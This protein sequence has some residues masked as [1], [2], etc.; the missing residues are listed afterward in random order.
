MDV[1]FFPFDIQ[2]CSMKF[3]SWSYDGV[4]VDLQHIEFKPTHDK[5][6]DKVKE[7]VVIENGIDL[8]DFYR[9]TEWDLLAIPAQKNVKR[10]TCCIETYPDIRF[11]ITLRR[12]TLFYTVN[13]I[14][15]CVA[16]SGLTVLVFYLP[17]DS[18]EK[19]TMSISILV[20]LTM[21]FLLLAEINPPTS[22]V[23]PLIGKYLLFTMILLTL[24]IMITVVVLNVHFRSSSTHNMSPWVR[25]VFLNVLPR[26]LLMRRP[27]PGDDVIP[28]VVVRTLNGIEVRDSYGQDTFSKIDNDINYDYGF[29]NFNTD[30][31][32]NSDFLSVEPEA[33]RRPSLMPPK[34]S[35]AFDGVSFIASNIKE[36][37][38]SKKVGKHIIFLKS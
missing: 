1:E 31:R 23:V 9:S 25:R 28:R 11:N 21:F 17:S 3:G 4:A 15:P 32:D 37:D 18:G 30:V 27:Y 12:K 2:R 7:L 34:V 20:S 13:L 8:V 29:T 10:Y 6:V 5:V 36:N 38:K 16:I 24:S 35:K 33:A 22:L 19:I 14:I 26:L